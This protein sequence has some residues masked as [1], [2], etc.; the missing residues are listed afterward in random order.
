MFVTWANYAVHFALCTFVP[1]VF[2][3]IR[4]KTARISESCGNLTR[5]TASQL[6]Y[7]LNPNKGTGIS[8]R[9]RQEAVVL[10]GYLTCVRLPAY[11]LS[12]HRNKIRAN[13]LH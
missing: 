6:Q 8:L 4:W 3:Y 13:F 10:H 2:T 1:R 5:E 9:M 11:H 7:F 12:S